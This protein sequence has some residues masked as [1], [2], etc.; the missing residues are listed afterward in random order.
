ML[1]ILKNPCEDVFYSNVRNARKEILLCAPFVKNNVVKKIL[2]TKDNSSNLE[3]VTNSNLG[4]FASKGSDIEAIKF[5][6]NEEVDVFNYQNLHAKIYIFDKSTAIITSSNLTYSGLVRNYEY[7]VMISEDDNS[8]N[9]ILFDYKSMIEGNG[10]CGKFTAKKIQ[11]IEAAIKLL[12]DKPNLKMD[13]QGDIILTNDSIPKL[14]NNFT[15]WKKEVFNLI[16]MVEG[17]L[18]SN[19]ELITHLNILKEK[20]PNAKTPDASMRKILQEFRDMGIIKF[21]DNKGHYKKLWE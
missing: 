4:A 12:G 20:F 9:E 10:L 11:E 19:K 21:V 5:L 16:C 15:G 17:E 1:T 2:E 7:G 18:F 3:L 8:L 13:N 6:V 14:I